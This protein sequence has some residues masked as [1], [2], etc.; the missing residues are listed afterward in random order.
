MLQPSLAHVVCAYAAYG[1]RTN[2]FDT[3]SVTIRPGTTIKFREATSRC[4]LLCFRLGSTK[5][6]E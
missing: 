6:G 1:P 2:Y 3:T 5:C 4:A